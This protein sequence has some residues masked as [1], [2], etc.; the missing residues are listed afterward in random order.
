LA[1]ADEAGEGDVLTRG[2]ATGAVSVVGT[3]AFAVVRGALVAA[4]AGAPGEHACC[5]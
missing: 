1:G 4:S 3:L 2:G 5:W